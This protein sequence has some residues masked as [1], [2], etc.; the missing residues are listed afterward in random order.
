MSQERDGYCRQFNIVPLHQ[1]LY[2]RFGKRALELLLGVPAL[3]LVSPVLILSALLIRLDSR[4]PIL[5]LQERLGRYGQTFVAFK[6]RTMTDRPRSNS[7]EIKPGHTEV[8]RVGHWLRRFKIDELPQL[9]NVI[10]GDMSLVGPRPAL[11]E[12]L[13]DYDEAG[14]LRLLVRPGLA[15][16][17]QVSGNIYLTWPERWQWDAEYVR[18]LSLIL[19]LQVL[20]RTVGVVLL[21]EER[22]LRR[23]DTVPMP[24][25]IDATSEAAAPDDDHSIRPAA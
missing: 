4:G 9:L 12:H 1:G 5:F 3:I 20:A 23:P 25:P 6:L 15:G 17:A 18:R 13:S 22:F 19:D 8:T 24:P 11:P 14:H 7:Y 16:L 21:G 2:A 10:R